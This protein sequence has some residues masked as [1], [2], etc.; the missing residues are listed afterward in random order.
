MVGT[1]AR[2]A[3]GGHARL[4]EF[5]EL[6]DEVLNA[7]LFMLLG[8]EATRIAFSAGVAV[9]AVIAVGVVLVARF[10]SVAASV[11]MLRPFRGPASRHA[12]KILTWGG[13]RGG[14]SVALALSLVPGADRDTILAMTYA[15]VC[16]TILAQ[17][18]TLTRV[19]RALGLNE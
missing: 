6:V 10:A 16:F 13:L 17:G 2:A 5:W 7:V 15:V 11:A 12:V 14:L 1:H 8:L 18:L 9:A 3:T 4:R 19:L